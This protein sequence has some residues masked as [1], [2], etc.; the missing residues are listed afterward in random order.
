MLGRDPGIKTGDLL[1]GKGIQ[2]TT[3]TLHL[4]FNSLAGILL[5]PFKDNMLQK[6]RR[7]LHV[8]RFKPAAGAHQKPDADTLSVF[9]F[10]ADDPQA[11]AYPSLL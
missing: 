5:G 3:H 10:I 11:I 9:H 7:A 8:I 4:L 1:G 6:M 2:S